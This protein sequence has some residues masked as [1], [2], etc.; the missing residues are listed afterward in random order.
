M[1]PVSDRCAY[2]NA[3]ARV[4][5]RVQELLEECHCVYCGELRAWG[6]AHI[7]VSTYNQV[8]HDLVDTGILRPSGVPGS[9][10]GVYVLADANGVT[11]GG[12]V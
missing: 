7:G 9:G 10:V 6:E 5:I 11:R 3:V 1:L 8:I 4:V 12:D 2:A